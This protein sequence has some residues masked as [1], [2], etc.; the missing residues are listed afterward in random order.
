MADL[1]EAPSEE[2]ASSSELSEQQVQVKAKGR[3]RNPVFMSGP[4]PHLSFLIDI[5][6]YRNREHPNRSAPGFM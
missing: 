4:A 2:Q 3:R 1:N 5:D 6:Q